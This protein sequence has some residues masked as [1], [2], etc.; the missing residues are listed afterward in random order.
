MKLTLGMGMSV[1]GVPSV[2]KSSSMFLSSIERSATGRSVCDVRMRFTC[3]ARAGQ[4][5]ELRLHEMTGWMWER[6]SE[7]HRVKRTYQR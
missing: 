7:A 5:S 4:A 2:P 1:S 3:K 6:S